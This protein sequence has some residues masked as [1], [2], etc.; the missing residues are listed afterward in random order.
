MN[1]VQLMGRLTKDVDLRQAPQ[2]DYMG[3]FTLAV[4][5]NFKNKQGEVEADFIS[6]QIWGKKAE[7]LA[8]YVKKGQRVAVDG[9]IRTGS[10]DNKQGQRVYTT[11]VN[12]NNIYFIESRQQNNQGHQQPQQNFNSPFSDFEGE[13]IDISA[14]DLPF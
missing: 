14:D 3:R 2:G 12:V 9:N 7:I 4:E 11:D 5:R 8:R 6:C 13:S 10:Y 1:N